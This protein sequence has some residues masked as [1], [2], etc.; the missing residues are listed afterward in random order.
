MKTVLFIPGYPENLKS[1]DYHSV[2]KAIDAKG[3]K[4]V[5]VPIKWDRTTIDD[6]VRQVEEVYKKHD[7]SSTILA[8]FSYGAMTAFVTATHR[9]PAELWL[10]SLSGFFSEDI[11]G[12]VM[13]KSWLTSIGHRRTSAFDRLKYR[14]LAPE[15]KCKVLL[16]AGQEEIDMWPTMK[17]RTLESP[18][19]IKQSTLTIVPNVGHDVADSRYIKQIEQ[20]I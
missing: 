20:L 12:A 6:W 18:K 11:N 15:I 1:R 5:F 4:T 7:V 10:F 14:K 9:N 17:H 16:F 2:L 13:K 3:Y 8:G 19:Y